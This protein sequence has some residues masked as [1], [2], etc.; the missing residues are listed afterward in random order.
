[1]NARGLRFGLMLVVLAAVALRLWNIAADLPDFLEEAIPFRFALNLWSWTGGPTDWNPHFFNYPSLTLYLH[2]LLQKS[3][4]IVAHAVGLARTPADWF[5][6]YLADPSGMVIPARV[7]HVAF[8][9][10]AV[11]LTGLVA[12]RLRRG[13]GVPAALLAALSATLLNTARTISTDT[14]MGALALGALERMLAWRERG[15]AWR[16]VAAVVL[17]GLATGAKYPAALVLVPLAW[18]LW[19]RD[20]GRG[21]AL[22]PWCALGA[23]GVFLLTTPY[24][25]LDFTAFRRDFGFESLHVAS[26]HLGQLTGSGLPFHVHNLLRDLGPVGMASLGVS[27]AL[28][29]PR[30]TRVT[31]VA[32]WLYLVVFLGPIA[33]ARF[34]AE[35]YLVPVIPAAA[36]LAAAAVLELAAR[37]AP[38]W[39]AAVAVVLLGG[40]LI[41]VLVTGTRA[42]ARGGRFTQVEARRWMEANLSTRELVVDE[43][44]GPELPAVSARVTV[45]TSPI[46]R[47]AGPE[48]RRRYLARPW[49]HAVSL[50]LFVSGRV[51]SRLQ[52]PGG[53]AVDV[54]VFPAAVDFNGVIY[55][56]R[57]FDG[58]DVVV[59]SS[60]VRGRFKADPARYA[61]ACRFYRLLDSTATVLTRIAPGDRLSGPEIVAYRLGPR[62]HEA[63][64]ASSPPDLLW[65]VASVPAEYRRRATGVL[66]ARWE[67][68]APWSAPGRPAPWVGSL[69]GVYDERLRPFVEDMAVNLVDL[70][71][72]GA[73]RPFAEATLLLLPGD[74]VAQMT[75]DICIRHVGSLNEDRRP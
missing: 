35:R 6:L 8:D 53:G 62:A 42:A 1:M 75:Q 21:L 9:A 2:L 5:V 61:A 12:E 29:V 10:L 59:T 74:P 67:G 13:A 63:L 66:G 36:A 17:A 41:P 46:F 22:W 45:E 72:F 56:G 47:A 26:G 4:W 31:A 44:W 54:D 19:S 71:R 43:A 28:M 58:V 52:M 60:A 11:G 18:I 16:L 69:A 38:R 33:S 70:G 15:G 37:S 7:A 20:R 48:A 50:P 49:F 68:G 57:L 73:A 55:D 27:A 23:L 30:A 64:A 25:L 39:R 34:G 24:A 51:S 40:L 65:W 32:V 14:V 3:D